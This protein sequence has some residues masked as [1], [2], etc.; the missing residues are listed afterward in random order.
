MGENVMNFS[1]RSRR[2]SARI[3][4][5]AMAAAGVVTAAPSMS[6]ASAP[7][8]SPGRGS[9][10]TGTPPLTTFGDN[11]ALVVIKSNNWTLTVNYTASGSDN[12]LGIGLERPVTT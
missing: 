2:L 7:A 1:R 3:V 10:L 12:M 8:V 5:G 11:G 9:H 4:L 6:G